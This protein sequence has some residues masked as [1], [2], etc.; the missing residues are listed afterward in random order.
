LIECAELAQ[1]CKESV[2][3][4]GG[5]RLIELRLRQRLAQQLGNVAVEIGPRLAQTNAASRQYAS[6]VA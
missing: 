4:F 2:A 3:I 5:Q 1:I 6:V